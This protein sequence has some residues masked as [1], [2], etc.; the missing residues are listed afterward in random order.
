MI[1]GNELMWHTCVQMQAHTP[2]QS[3]YIKW[4]TVLNY[5][6]CF[7]IAQTICVVPCNLLYPLQI[8]HGD[9]LMFMIHVY[10]VHFIGVLN[11][12]MWCIYRGNNVGVFF[13]GQKSFCAGNEKNSNT[14]GMQNR[15]IF[16]PKRQ[17]ILYSTKIIQTSTA[18][19]RHRRVPLR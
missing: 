7:S 9:K 11:A 8:T 2:L 10:S 4:K 1:N 3:A 17:F 18:T 12:V 5:N 14:I 15:R 16:T 6:T 13:K 19:K